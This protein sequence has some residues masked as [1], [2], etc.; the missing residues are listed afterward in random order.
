MGYKFGPIVTVRL[1]EY[2]SWIKKGRHGKFGYSTE[3]FGEPFFSCIY[4]N[5]ESQSKRFYET[6]PN[7]IKR[8]ILFILTQLFILSG[9]KIFG[10]LE[11]VD[12]LALFGNQRVSGL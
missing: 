1:V 4:G 9:S 5:N 2:E 8:W 12:C 7:L 11:I 10:R 3:A 6:F